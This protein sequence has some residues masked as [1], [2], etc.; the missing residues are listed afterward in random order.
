MNADP[1]AAVDVLLVDDDP[2]AVLAVRSTL[3]DA[4]Y[5][6]A[7]VPSGDAALDATPLL[8]P[9]LV[10]LDV[11]MPDLDGFSVCRRLRAEDAST[12]FPVLF[13]SSSSGVESRIAGLRAGG[14]DYLIKPCEPAELLARVAAQLEAVALREE[15]AERNM[16]LAN[17]NRALEE[18]L[19]AASRVQTAMLPRVTSLENRVGFAWRSLPCERLGGDA[20]NVLRLPS[21]GAVLYL[22]DASGHGVSASLLSVAASYLV[23]ASAAGLHGNAMGEIPKPSAILNQLNK[24]VLRIAPPGMFVTVLVGV[25]DPQGEAFTFSSA[26]HPGPLLSRSGAPPQFLDRPAPPAGIRAW[27]YAEH[28]VPLRPGDRLVLYSDGVYEQRSPSGQH[29]GRL[30]LAACLEDSRGLALDRAL[31][32]IVSALAR[33]RFTR[34]IED[35]MTM[36]ALE[37]LRTETPSGAERHGSSQTK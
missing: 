10:I 36:L 21:G 1:Q 5:T 12:H 25:V 2:V 32:G 3:T 30:A 18:G 29:F 28:R 14:I 15:L 4:G 37:V 33:W 19:A 9:R 13:L 31:D 34:G 8:R 16:R 35:D 7:A 22:L 11:A 17:A 20:I 24:V 26:G 23:S 6:V 27:R